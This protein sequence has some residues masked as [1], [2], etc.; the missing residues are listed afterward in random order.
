MALHLLAL[1][2]DGMERQQTETA[3][4]REE[5]RLT[6]LRL[7]KGR[8]EP[9]TIDTEIEAWPG[10]RRPGFHSGAP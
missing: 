6:R 3:G 9:G 5:K 8:D 4:S 1:S 7:T 2:P 10:K